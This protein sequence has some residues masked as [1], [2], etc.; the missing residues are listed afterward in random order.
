MQGYTPVFDY[1]IHKFNTINNPETIFSS[2]RSQYEVYGFIDN[3]D[4]PHDEEADTIARNTDIEL[5][6]KYRDILSLRKNVGYENSTSTYAEYSN[7]DS[8]HI[9]MS[10][11]LFA[12]IKEPLNK[13][14][15]IGGGF[16]NWLFLNQKQSFNKWIIIDLPHVL[17][18]QKWY[19]DNQN[20]NPELY[21]QISAFDNKKW[22]SGDLV[23]GSHSL[24]EF[25][26]DVFYK[27]FEQIISK[28]KYFFYCYHNTMPSPDLINAKLL[29]INTKF[30]L[31]SKTIS[32]N[33]NVSNCLFVSKNS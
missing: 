23:I 21:T 24:S 22:E 30:T 16:G 32:E 4:N 8:R 19:L 27:Y 15:E 17:Q 31:I 26:F 13:I 14:I 1:A 2:F 12:N 20:V 28:S 25:S 6:Q 10:V 18:L 3:G 29:V 11:F 7:L 9:M 33:N 5:Y